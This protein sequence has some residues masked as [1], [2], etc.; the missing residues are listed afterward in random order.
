[1]IRK[2]RNFGSAIHRTR[3]ARR[4]RRRDQQNSYERTQDRRAPPPPAHSDNQPPAVCGQTLSSDPTLDRDERHAR[5]RELAGRRREP[6]CETIA[7]SIAGYA[8]DDAR[9]AT[10]QDAAPDP[11]VRPDHRFAHGDDAM[12]DARSATLPLTR[13]VPVHVGSGSDR[14]EC[15]SGAKQVPRHGRDA[16]SAFRAREVRYR[17][18]WMLGLRTKRVK[19]TPGC[20]SAV[21]RRTSSGVLSGRARGCS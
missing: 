3:A 15:C 7:L 18:V 19:T 17:D 2:N 20:A 8:F 16:T 11:N 13:K 10:R 5:G 14:Q 4:G 6:A 1:M 9:F 21:S 12:S